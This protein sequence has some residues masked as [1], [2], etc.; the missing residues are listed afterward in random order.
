[1]KFYS[2]VTILSENEDGEIGIEM[3]NKMTD[4]EILARI[5]ELEDEGWGVSEVQIDEDQHTWRPV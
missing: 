3:H 5:E 4:A 2:P 1:M